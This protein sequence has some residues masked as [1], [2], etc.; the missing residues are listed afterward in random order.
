MAAKRTR[1]ILGAR[2]PRRTAGT[3]HAAAA[4]QQVADAVISGQELAVEI[5]LQQLPPDS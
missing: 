1:R 3:R 2:K 4:G 5:V